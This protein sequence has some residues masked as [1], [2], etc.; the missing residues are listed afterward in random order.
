MQ[1]L[2]VFFMKW[3]AHILASSCHKCFRRPIPVW[4]PHFDEVLTEYTENLM[5]LLSSSLIASLAKILDHFVHMTVRYNIFAGVL[6]T[7]FVERK[8]SALT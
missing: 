2:F 3:I 1:L 8:G 5:I 6:M 7:H 4:T